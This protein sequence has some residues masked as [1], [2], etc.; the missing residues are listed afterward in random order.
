VRQLWL[1]DVACCAVCEGFWGGHAGVGVCEGGDGGES[2][3]ER[4]ER[5]EVVRVGWARSP[6]RHLDGGPWGWGARPWLELRPSSQVIW[7]HDDLFTYLVCP[8]YSRVLHLHARAT[9]TLS[10]THGLF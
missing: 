5:E 8:I 10:H 2:G 4:I 3:G 6:E 7:L 9:T 1:F